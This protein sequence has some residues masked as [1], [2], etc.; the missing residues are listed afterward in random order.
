MVTIGGEKAQRAVLVR[1]RLLAARGTGSCTVVDP[2]SP[3]VL[4]A[5]DA[6]DVPEEPW[7]MDGTSCWEPPE[8]W[9]EQS[10]ARLPDASDLAGMDREFEKSGSPELPGAARP[11]G[12]PER[13]WTGGMDGRP[14][15]DRSF[16]LAAAEPGAALVSALLEADLDGL[17][18]YDVVEA[19]AAWDRVVSWAQAQQLEAVAVLADR[20]SMNPPWPATAGRVARPNVTGEELALRLGRTRRAANVMVD[21]A[22]ALVGPLAP[23]GELLER[24]RL[25]LAQV[26]AI[27][28]GLAGV[29]DAGC[30]DVQDLVLDRAPERSPGQLAK[31]VSRALIALDPAG[32]SA[33]VEQACRGR[34]VDRPRA[35]AHG[36]AGMWA[37]LPADRAITIDAD[38]DSH[39]RGLRAAGDGRTLDQLRADLFVDA[40]TG[41]AHGDTPA[42]GGTDIGAPSG[43]GS[44]VSGPVRGPAARGASGAAAA[45][46][47][48]SP[49]RRDGWTPRRAQVNV[50][51]PLT[52]LLGLTEEP[53]ELA[54]YGPIDAGTARRLAADGTWRRIVTDPTAGTV[55]D[56]G[57]T[58]YRPP[59]DLDAHVRHRDQSCARPG[60]GASAFGCDLDHTVDFHRGGGRGTTSH[61][62][63]GPL[64]PRDHQIKTDGGFS[65]E[66]PSAG[67]FRWTTPTGHSYEHTPGRPPPLPAPEVRPR[68]SEA[69]MGESEVRPRESEVGQGEPQAGEPPDG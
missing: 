19:V 9:F 69:G 55:L 56:V 64:C 32:A 52:T 24:G 53:G 47:P 63:L 4:V 21:M 43:G 65:L 20:E 49:R 18:D 28:D 36:M 35:L 6:P 29:P 14:A 51:V 27:H 23:T 11:S 48:R 59:A 17:D 8:E 26:R 54:G 66:Q 41:A 60:C 12:V 38:L 7:D 2:P 5:P 34:R 33:R 16:D 68:E 3:E 61:D 1:A 30:A 44:L 25:D 50:T 15:A 39:A 42:P 22:R 10:S 58:T 37:V 67:T 62:N 45:P 46:P 13:A 40:L 31:D 57:R